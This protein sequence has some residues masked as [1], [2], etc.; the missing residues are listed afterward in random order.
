MIQ[1]YEF[2]CPAIYRPLKINILEKTAQYFNAVVTV[3]ALTKTTPLLLLAIDLIN[4]TK[5]MSTPKH[6]H[7]PTGVR[8]SAYIEMYVC[9]CT[10]IYI[11]ACVFVLLTSGV[12]LCTKFDCP[13]VIVLPVQIQISLCVGMCLRILQNISILCTCLQ[14]SSPSTCAT[15][16]MA[17]ERHATLTFILLTVRHKRCHITALRC[18]FCCSI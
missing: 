17:T 8:G 5:T 9:I 16:R 2:R 14:H 3:V 7:V 15:A 1:K 11:V 10:H 12:F 13:G 18:K 4:Q 6:S